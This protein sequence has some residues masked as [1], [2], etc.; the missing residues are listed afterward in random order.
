M[1]T[2][3]TW[4]SVMKLVSKW[5]PKVASTGVKTPVGW[6]ML[7]AVSWLSVQSAI[8]CSTGEA[9]VVVV[10]R[11]SAVQVRTP[12][13]SVDVVPVHR[14]TRLRVPYAAI[15]A[16]FYRRYPPLPPYAG[17]LPLPYPYA[18]AVPPAF[19]VIDVPVYP[20][21]FYPGIS[22]F[23][24]PQGVYPDFATSG[25]PL[26]EETISSSR[27]RL[28]SP[29]P[30]RLRTAAET[31]ARTLS[32]REDGDV[33][34]NYL[35][36]QRIIENV[37]YGRPASELQDLIVNYDGVVTNG[38]L[39]SIEY[40]RGFATSRDL[41]RQYLA[42]RGRSQLPSVEQVP[43]P[44]QAVPM[45]SVPAPPTP[46]VPAIEPQQETPDGR[47]AVGQKTPDAKTSLGNGQTPEYNRF[48][49]DD[50]QPRANAKVVQPTP[51]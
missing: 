47:D 24:Y 34:L 17:F 22:R 46:Q 50:Q 8:L 5:I 6:M 44:A 2:V 14:R 12:F 25:Q 48:S 36:P 32:L 11:A 1:W 41:L 26:L 30:E 35:G 29:L 37:D 9:Q 33:W 7:V 49:E 20:R 10:G 4:G 39:K 19:P 15:D 23:E 42:S 21:F 45:D 51:L 16:G 40:A 13:V 28:V 38:S 31:L 18:I 3:E 43:M 27:P